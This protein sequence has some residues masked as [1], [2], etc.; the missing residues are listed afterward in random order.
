MLIIIKTKVQSSSDIDILV[1][2]IVVSLQ[3]GSNE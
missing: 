2:C 1:L 3:V